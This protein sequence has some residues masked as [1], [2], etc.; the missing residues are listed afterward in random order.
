VSQKTSS[1]I[2]K[3]QKPWMTSAEHILVVLILA[4]PRHSL[5]GAG[6]AG[7]TLFLKHLY[8]QAGH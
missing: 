1:R 6:C 5:T 8:N 4:L 7:K 3:I 2:A